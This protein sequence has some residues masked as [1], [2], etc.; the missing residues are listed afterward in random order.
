MS[1][2]TPDNLLI[3]RETQR[4]VIYLDGQYLET[5]EPGRHYMPKRYRIFSRTC[6]PVYSIF[7]VEVNER[8]LFIDDQGAKSS[9]DKDIKLHAVLDFKVID[10]ALAV[11]TAEKYED[12]LKRDTGI[13]IE[14]VASAMDAE[15]IK[16]S[17]DAFAEKVLAELRPSVARYGIEVI[18]LRLTT[19]K[20][21]KDEKSKDKDDKDK[22]LIKVNA[23]ISLPKE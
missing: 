2:R 10:A 1:P 20:V 7:V 15:E 23:D 21:K 12:R 22:K 13:A 16:S 14:R 11:R 4:A 19:V 9:D 6:Y 18:G 8:E 5:L 17:R 3:V